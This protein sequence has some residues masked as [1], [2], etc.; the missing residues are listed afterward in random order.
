MKSGFKGDFPNEALKSTSEVLNST[1]SKDKFVAMSNPFFVLNSSAVH[2]GIS[3]ETKLPNSWADLFKGVNMFDSLPEKDEMTDKF[4]EIQENSL[5]E[6]T[7]ED[8]LI[9][10]S[11]TE[12]NISV[13]GK[14]FGR[15][16]PLSLVQNV[17]PK[18]WKVK[19]QCTS[20]RLGG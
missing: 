11:R 20:C 5:N 7:I 8:D 1:G 13:Y 2:N 3:K 17:M 15:T 18:L 19:K 9:R 10:I 12:W 16:P 6:V 4:K 14:F